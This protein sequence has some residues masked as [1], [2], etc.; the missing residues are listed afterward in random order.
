[1]SYNHQHVSHQP[2]APSGPYPPPGPD[3]PPPPTSVGYNRT[4]RSPSPPQPGYQG[5]CYEGYPSS[6][7]GLLPPRLPP[8]NEYTHN[9]CTSFLTGCLATLCCCCLLEDCVF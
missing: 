8:R 5:Y 3:F 2:L 9:G 1:M 6:S 7:P 4:H